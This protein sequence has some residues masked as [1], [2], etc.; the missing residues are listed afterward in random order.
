MLD[1]GFQE[2]VR[3]GE[4]PVSDPD[5]QASLAIIDSHIAVSTPSGTG[6]YRYGDAAAAGSADGYGDCYQPSQTSCTIAGAPWP[7]TDTGTGHLWPVLSGERAES[8]VAEGNTGGAESLLQAMINFSVRR[9]AGARAGMG[10]PGPGGLAVRQRPGDGV[11][12]VH[13]RQGGRLGVAADL[14]PGAG[15]AAD[16]LGGHR[17]QRG[18][19]ARHHRALRHARAAWHAAGDDHR[20]GPGSTLATAPPP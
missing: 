11:D 8:D 18:H 17:P 10:R 6:Y 16:R 1:G 12:R 7:P 9:R 15:T 2:L 19:P 13:R 5:V 4:L 14:G 20:P 3:L